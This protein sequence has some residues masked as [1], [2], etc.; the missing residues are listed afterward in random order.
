MHE[1]VLCVR[2]CAAAALAGAVVGAELHTPGAFLA[3]ARDG[4]GTFGAARRFPPATNPGLVPLP[5]SSPGLSFASTPI[6]A[7]GTNG[8]GGCSGGG[9]RTSGGVTTIFGADCSEGVGG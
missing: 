4:G 6:G 3:S 2:A 1:Y 7:Y 8:V 9:G 5:P